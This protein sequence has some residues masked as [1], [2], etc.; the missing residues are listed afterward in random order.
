MNREIDIDARAFIVRHTRLSPAPLVPEIVLYQASDMLGLW[1]KMADRQ[2]SA[3]PPYWAFAWAGGQAVARYI[4]DHPGVV[5]DKTVLDLGTGSGLCA[6]AAPRAGAAHVK[7]VDVDPYCV[8]AVALNAEANGVAVEVA[9]ADLLGGPAPSVDIVLA[10]DVCYEEPFAD[11]ALAWLADAHSHG[12]A[13]LIG[14]PSRAHFPHEMMTRLARYDV[15]TPRTLEGA[16]TTP[17]GVYTFA[18]R[19][20]KP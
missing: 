9:L 14:D 18:E 16:T 6:I 1:Q 8:D 12:V 2:D 15:P 17:T 13:V 19:L 20:S 4:L 11:R 3:P 10:G 7:A 5:A